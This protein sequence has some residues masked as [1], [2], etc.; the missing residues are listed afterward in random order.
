[1]HVRLGTSHVVTGCHSS[2]TVSD[3]GSKTNAELVCGP[4]SG[5][6]RIEA[7]DPT[8][9][10]F[11]IPERSWRCVDVWIRTPHQVEASQMIIMT[12]R[13]TITTTTV[14][15]FQINFVADGDF[16]G[17]VQSG[18]GEELGHAV[19]SIAAPGPVVGDAIRE[20]FQIPFPQ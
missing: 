16:E 17:G 3:T 15:A 18:L 9:G 12:G 4:V 8:S 13:S 19:K 2:Q 5:G 11:P 7:R 6:G 10:T 20:G 14:V 1:M